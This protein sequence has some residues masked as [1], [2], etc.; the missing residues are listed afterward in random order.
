VCMRS[1]AIDEVVA[2][3]EADLLPPTAGVVASR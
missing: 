3:I 1:I 2:G